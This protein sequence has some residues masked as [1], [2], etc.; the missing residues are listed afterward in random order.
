MTVDA[1]LAGR[2]MPVVSDPRQIS[3][4]LHAHLRGLI[5]SGTLPPG[6]V[7]KQSEL[8]RVLSVSRT[9]LREAFRMLQEEGL[10]EADV[11]QRARVSALDPQALD[12]LYAAR[13]SLECLGVHMTAGELRNHESRDA[14]R[15]LKAMER[16]VQAEN[17][18][19][20]SE[21]HRRF[22]AAL[23][24]RSGAF[25]GRTIA[26]YA[27]HSERYWRLYTSTHPHSLR[28]RH[29]EHEDLL[30]AVAEGG[31]PRAAE[32][33]AQHLSSSG[34]AVLGVLDATYVP[35]AITSAVRMITGGLSDDIAASPASSA[36][37]AAV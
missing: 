15:L 24:I 28:A 2:P 31:K 35:Q 37:D 7:M 10:I 12:A 26:S 6:T 22:H 34:L 8:A 25:V 4:S 9:P 14:S 20:W 16:A 36:L 13:I 18:E 3:V 17:V 1:L 19:S 29:H 32:L 21:L 30:Q 33:M 11:N 27:A 23:V 5:M